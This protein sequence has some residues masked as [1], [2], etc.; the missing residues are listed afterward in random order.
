MKCPKI[1]VP[2][3]GYV[4]KKRECGN[5]LNSACGIRCEVGYTLVGKSI[6]LCQ[7]NATW[8]GTTPS[9]EGK[10]IILLDCFTINV[11]ACFS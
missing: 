3:H 10:Y 5:V 9:C 6:R 1:E 7:A 4:V 2:E 11:P 8:T